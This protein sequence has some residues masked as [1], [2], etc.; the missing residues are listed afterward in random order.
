M[1]KRSKGFN[2]IIGSALL[3][4]VSVMAIPS[5]NEAEAESPPLSF[6]TLNGDIEETEAISTQ[7]TMEKPQPSTDLV[8]GRN[9][10]MKPPQPP[11]PEPGPEPEPEPEPDPIDLG[12]PADLPVLKGIS[13]SNGNMMAILDRSIVAQGDVL[14][15]GFK[16]LSIGEGQV[17]VSR[18]ERSFTLQLEN[19]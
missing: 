14:P 9:P 19:K 12:P 17:E 4:G 8:W 6:S 15:S 3:A 7:V 13:N 11:P 16:V 10:F 5:P 18:D 1:A 2:L